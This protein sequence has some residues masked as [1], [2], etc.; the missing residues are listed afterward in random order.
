MIGVNSGVNERPA[1]PL[2]PV[3]LFSQETLCQINDNL[4]SHRSDVHT[5]PVSEGKKE[6]E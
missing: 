2:E 6:W 5:L 1:E 4:D 3:F